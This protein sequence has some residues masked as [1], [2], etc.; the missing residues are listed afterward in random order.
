MCDGL[1]AN[2]AASVL[3]TVGTAVLQLSHLQA[4]QIGLLLVVFPLH[5]LHSL[6]YLS[7]LQALQETP[8]A[9]LCPQPAAS[10]GSS[11]QPWLHKFPGEQ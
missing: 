11:D 8:G 4:A 1:V 3:T 6:C 10:E 9:W 5:W 2:V 7:L